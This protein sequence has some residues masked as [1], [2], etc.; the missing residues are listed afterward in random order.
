M[1]M[2]YWI[3]ENW[4]IDKAMVHIGECPFCRNGR[5]IHPGREEGRNGRWHGPIEDLE[6]ARAQARILKKNARDCEFCL[7][8]AGPPGS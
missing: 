5:G 8:R 1:N 7:A 6:Q 3:Y 2:A 4:A